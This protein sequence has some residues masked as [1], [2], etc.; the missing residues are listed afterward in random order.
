MRTG[1]KKDERY[2]RKRKIMR[3]RGRERNMRAE[4][5]GRKE[6]REGEKDK[7]RAGDM[8]KDREENK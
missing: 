7:L 8:S 3:N 2:S 5:E 1:N 6:E 4:K